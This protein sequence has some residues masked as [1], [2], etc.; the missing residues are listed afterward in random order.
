LPSFL[1]VFP[2]SPIALFFSLTILVVQIFS[3]TI[4]SPFPSTLLKSNHQDG[5]RLFVGRRPK[6]S[7]DRPE[8]RRLDGQR[9]SDTTTTASSSPPSPDLLH[10]EQFWVAARL[11]AVDTTRLAA[12]I[13]SSDGGE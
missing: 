5:W 1:L 12:T 3:L 11:T 10:H 6:T 9:A 13:S 2:F 4:Q 8:D 7:Q